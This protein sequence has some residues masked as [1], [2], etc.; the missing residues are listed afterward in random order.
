VC[1]QRSTIIFFYSN[2]RF[3]VTK[4]RDRNVGSTCPD[5][6]KP[7]S[8]DALTTSLAVA[9]AGAVHHVNMVPLLRSWEPVAAACK[10]LWLFFARFVSCVAWHQVVAPVSAEHCLVCL[11]SHVVQPPRP[12]PYSRHS[13]VPDI[14]NEAISS[15]MSP[16]EDVSRN[17]LVDDSKPQPQ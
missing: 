7:L 6:G 12:K 8:S 2:C 13:P 14:T 15:I 1:F 5:L 4:K 3:R 10:L 11:R 16:R 9:M 17:H